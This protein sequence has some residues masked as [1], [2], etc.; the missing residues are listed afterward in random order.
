[1]ILGKLNVTIKATSSH[2]IGEDFGKNSLRFFPRPGIFFTT[3]GGQS[4]R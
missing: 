1:M 3:S 2:T 4:V